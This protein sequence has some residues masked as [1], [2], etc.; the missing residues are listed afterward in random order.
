MKEVLK[1]TISSFCISVTCGA[2]MNLLI[3]VVVRLVTE[4]ED[5]STISSEYI[6]M[7]PSKSIAVE[8]Y[9]LLYGVIGAAFSAMAFIYEKVEIGFVLQNLIYVLLTGM[10]WLPIVVFIWQLHR[11]PQAFYGTVSGFVVTYV[12]MTVV[13]YKI[14]KK[15]IDAI[16]LYLGQN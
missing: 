12:I 1:R 13:G 9:V 4:M 7:F 15:E 3:E 16:N 11:Y 10:I 8:V 5:F 6:E 2:L 14:T